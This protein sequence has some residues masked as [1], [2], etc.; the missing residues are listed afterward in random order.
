M[1]RSPLEHQVDQP[2]NQE[3]FLPESSKNPKPILS[4]DLKRSSLASRRVGS[5]T[6][7]IRNTSTGEVERKFELE[8][9]GGLLLGWS[10]DLNMF[11][12]IPES[13]TIKIGEL[14]SGEIKQV[15]T[16]QEGGIKQAIF[17]FDCKYVA[18]IS[19]IRATITI[20]NVVT[21]Q[22]LLSIPNMHQ[23]PKIVEFSH[24][25]RYLAAAYYP[26]EVNI[27]DSGKPTGSIPVKETLSKTLVWAGA[28]A[29]S[30]DS[31]LL[32]V[33][34]AKDYF[35]LDSSIRIWDTSTM[36]LRETIITNTHTESLS[37]SSD[38][39]FLKSDRCC[40]VVRSNEADCTHIGEGIVVNAKR[41]GFYF[42]DDFS[43]IKLHGKKMIY[44]PAD[45]RKN[46]DHTE[47]FFA[48]KLFAISRSD[49]LPAVPTI[50]FCNR[51]EKFW[52]IELAENASSYV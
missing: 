48:E 7:A 13:H 51:A 31:R 19:R 2:T 42:S 52:L 15:F 46:L 43:W 33:A 20:W 16:H 9:F 36:M 24:D 41:I 40:L 27:W 29:F 34:Q 1:V 17:S 45:Y 47:D 8:R 39:S 25:S 44:I 18:L 3:S 4:E 37:F 32:A 49:H 30:H 28:L 35:H 5:R 10:H 12:W 22:M 38:G 6:L 50:A 21:G 26:S 23:E 11:A 14:S